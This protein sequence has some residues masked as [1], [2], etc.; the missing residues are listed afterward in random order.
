MSTLAARPTLRK[1]M[2]ADLEV[3][4]NLGSIV[5][6]TLSQKT[7]QGRGKVAQPAKLLLHKTDNPKFCLQNIQKDTC[8]DYL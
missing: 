7:K 3:E 6:Q 5:R 1:Q 4:A 8:G 2:Q